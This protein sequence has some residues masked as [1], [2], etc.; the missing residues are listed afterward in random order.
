LP[1]TGILGGWHNAAWPAFSANADGTS[2][3]ADLPPTFTG[4]SVN[5]NSMIF[6]PLRLRVKVNVSNQLLLKG[7]KLFQ[8]VFTDMLSRAVSGKLDDI[9]FFG[10]GTSGQPLGAFS[11]VTPL[12]WRQR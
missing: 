8:S 3:A 4:G 9:S 2:Q 7:N 12:T 6:S 10:S 11:T 5:S 1:K